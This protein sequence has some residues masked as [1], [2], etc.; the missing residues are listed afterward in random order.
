MPKILPPL[1]A[2]AHFVEVPEKEWEKRHAPGFRMLIQLGLKAQGLPPSPDHELLP[3]QRKWPG[4]KFLNDTP[5][6]EY[7]EANQ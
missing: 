1:K 2:S 5:P 4:Q 6:P 3:S 7:A